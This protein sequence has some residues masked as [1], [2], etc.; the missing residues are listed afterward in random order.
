M[1]KKSE[2]PFVLP[3]LISDGAFE[4]H[5]GIDDEAIQK[6]ESMYLFIK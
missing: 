6:A 5:P 2:L 4:E 1:Q 3:I